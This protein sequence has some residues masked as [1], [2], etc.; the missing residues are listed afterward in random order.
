MKAEILITI[1]DE[2]KHIDLQFNYPDGSS[3][4][5]SN[6]TDKGLIK[7]CLNICIVTA[8]LQ[9]SGKLKSEKN[10]GN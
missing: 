6:V 5:F 3:E 2:K 10:N 9:I 7:A 4:K 8:L 1:E